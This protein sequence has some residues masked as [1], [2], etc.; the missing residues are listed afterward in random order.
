MGERP[1]G[2]GPP[3]PSRAVTASMAVVAGILVGIIGALICELVEPHTPTAA[4]VPGAE[5]VRDDGG[6]A[7]ETERP[8]A[9]FR[10]LVGFGNR[11][12]DDAVLR[13]K[14]SDPAENP[15]GWAAEN[16]EALD[17][18]GRALE[19]YNEALELRH[20][21]HLVNRIRDANFKRMAARRR[22]LGGGGTN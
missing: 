19:Y 8:D 12:Y 9:R 14:R 15:D 13:L 2:S 5:D 16:D 3:G 7:T 4:A 21:N 20:E 11:C 18:L 1:D 10:R 22:K 17:L 6:P